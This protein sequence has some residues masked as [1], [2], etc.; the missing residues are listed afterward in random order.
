MVYRDFKLR[1][2]DIRI[3]SLDLGICG[4]SIPRPTHPCG[5]WTSGYW[6]LRRVF[7]RPAG[8]LIQP[9]L[10]FLSKQKM[11]S[12][13]SAAFI[14][15][16]ICR[17]R[18]HHTE[19]LLYIKFLSSLLSV[20]KWTGA[21]WCPSLRTAGVETYC[22]LVSTV[23]QWKET[24]S[25]NHALLAWAVHLAEPT[26][27]KWQLNNPQKWLLGRVLSLQSY[28]VH[29]FLGVSLTKHIGTY[30]WVDMCR[31]VV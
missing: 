21:L 28:T 9:L 11:F 22:P 1:L 27:D 3:Y 12:P 8:S 7:R 19:D 6:D 26:I 23:H 2:V 24:S 14:V 31:V 17:C 4:Q 5:Y 30:F 25:G 20:C 13:V 10:I 18:I 15:S 16:Q 29:T